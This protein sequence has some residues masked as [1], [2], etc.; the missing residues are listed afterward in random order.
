M[1]VFTFGERLKKVRMYLGLTQEQLANKL[2][3]EEQIKLAHA[4]NAI[5]RLETGKGGDVGF[6]MNLLNFYSKFIYIDSLF[7]N[8]FEIVGKESNTLKSGYI[9]GIA[10]A[11][12]EMMKNMLDIHIK[13]II[14]ILE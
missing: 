1:D 7:I 2:T 11:K 14:D 8:D 5:S 10:K 13:E 4:Q 12:I 6:L 9:G 3:E